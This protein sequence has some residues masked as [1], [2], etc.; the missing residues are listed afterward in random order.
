MKK[1]FL[2]LS[3]VF[4][5][6]FAAHAQWSSNGNNVYT[7]T[8]GNNVTI[9][10]AAPLVMNTASALFAGITP[11]QETVTGTSSADYSEVVTLRHIGVSADALTRQLG[12][13]FKLSSEVSTGESNKMGG[14]LLESNNIYAN[15]PSLSL[16]TSNTRRLTI[17]YGGNVGINTTTPVS[18]FQIASGISKFSSGRANGVDLAWGTSYI[19]FNAARSTSGTATWIIDG[20][21]SH[22]GG[23]VIYG[24]V[25]GNIYVA[26]IPSSGTT[27][28]SLADVDVKNNITFK[29]GYNGIVYAKAISVQTTGWPDYVFNP[30][31]RL[32]SLA[33]VKAYIDRKQHLPEIPSEEEIAKNGVNLGEMNKILVKKVEELTLYLIEMK[34]EHEALKS[35]VGKL[36][37]S[38]KAKENKKNRAKYLGGK[39]IKVSI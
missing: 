27:Q 9:G 18:T 32:P 22:N 15:N 38:L 39:N 6:F 37:D 13:I 25:L 29:I 21:G 35:L 12:L 31:Y 33:E 34:K 36:S 4:A 14:L 1:T 23:G 2:L 20:D 7:T 28:K 26:P 5:N 17:D 8:P 11:K 24:D 3:V 30:A 16:I 19:G 10:A